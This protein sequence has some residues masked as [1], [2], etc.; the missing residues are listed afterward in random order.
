MTRR[1][2]RPK[3]ADL[4]QADAEVLQVLALTSGNPDRIRRVLDSRNRLTHALAAHTVPLLGVEEVAR[5]AVRAL[6][7]VAEQ[8]TGKFVDTLLDQ[9]QPVA[10][11]RRLARVLSACRSQ[12]AVDGLVLGIGDAHRDVRTQCSRALL[13]VH[14]RDPGLH[15]DHAAIWTAVRQESAAPRPDARLVFT[16][17][18]LVLPRSTIRSAYRAL[19][20]G[21]GGLRG[22][23]LEYLHGVLPT[24]VRDSL[25]PHLSV[26]GLRVSTRGT[27]G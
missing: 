18:A 2:G 10:V 13:L 21:D 26:D 6:Q 24:Y 20:S 27:S 4:R 22:T 19:R 16:L 9:Q 23:A 25:W 12:R 17:L 15:V 8:H 3:R 5:D 14:A 11:R 7:A 1:P